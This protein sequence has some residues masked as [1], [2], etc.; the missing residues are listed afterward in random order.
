MLLSLT[1]FQTM[2]E[3]ALTKYRNGTIEAAQVI[4]EL[5]EIAMKMKLAVEE[6]EVEGL[7][8]DE[9]AF[10]DALLANGSAKEVMKDDQLRD[11]ARL[12]VEKVRTNTGVDWTYPQQMHRPSFVLK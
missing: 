2:L 6:G 8:E 10:Y 7:E 12:L 3:A 5:I 11:L 9:V 1:N 4:E